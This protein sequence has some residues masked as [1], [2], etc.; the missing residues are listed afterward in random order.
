VSS[1]IAGATRADQISANVAAAE[2]RLSPD[3]VAEVARLVA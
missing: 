1:V 2:W 3:D